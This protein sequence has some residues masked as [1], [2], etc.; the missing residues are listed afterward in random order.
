MSLSCS[1]NERV[2]YAYPLR[3]CL[4]GVGCLQDLLQTDVD[5]FSHWVGSNFICWTILGG[6]PW[7]LSYSTYLR[8][9]LYDFPF[10]RDPLEG[11]ARASIGAF[12]GGLTVYS[13]LVGNEWTTDVSLRR[14]RKPIDRHITW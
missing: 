4:I 12:E 13:P 10:N 11:H 9:I 6:A 8:Y 7:V 3:R 2:V 5:T 1:E 14:R